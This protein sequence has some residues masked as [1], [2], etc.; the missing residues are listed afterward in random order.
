MAAS[1][2]TPSHALKLDCIVCSSRFT[3]IKIGPGRHPRFCS[4][5][6][7]RQRKLQQRKVWAQENKR[8]YVYRPN[9][10]A[11]PYCSNSC[12][13]CGH[14]IFGP[15]SKVWCNRS[16]KEKF[17]RL[18]KAKVRPPR[19][20]KPKRL[21]QAKPAPD[22]QPCIACGIEFKPRSA[23]HRFCGS[24]DCN[25]KRASDL[26]RQKYVEAYVTPLPASC[27]ECG[28]EFSVSVGIKRRSYCSASCSKRN[29]KRT[30]RKAGK[31]RKRLQA[32]EPVNAFNVFA[33]DGWRCQL[34]G[35]STPRRLRGTYDDRA[36]ELDHIMPIS[37][38]GSHSYVNTQCACRKCNAFKGAKPL[39]QLRLVG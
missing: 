16:C 21:Y 36:P 9:K 5:E 3:F 23:S 28:R 4:G 14:T 24:K 31:L 2:I 11:K 17:G 29:S 39:G 19:L 32:V 10:N 12:R 1:A 22:V 34:C 6:C 7:E 26:A 37:S 13:H 8:A 18:V 33:R 15:A 20:T 25:S 30:S 27:R 35:T 38:G